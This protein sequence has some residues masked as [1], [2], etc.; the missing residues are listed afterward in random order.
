[1]K[2]VT[3]SSSNVCLTIHKGSPC[4]AEMSMFIRITPADQPYSC[5][6]ASL[7]NTKQ[8]RI[9]ARKMVLAA[10][11]VERWDHSGPKPVMTSRKV[12]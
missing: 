6:Y 1:M 4:H 8:G 3:Y 2:S 9:A 5:V 12:R 10:T 11:T 7:E